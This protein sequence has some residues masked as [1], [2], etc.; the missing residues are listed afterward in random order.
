MTTIAFIGA[1][2]IAKALMGGY[3]AGGPA[4]EVWA[5]DPIEAQLTTLPDGIRTTTNNLEA[6]TSAEI[7]VLCVKPNMLGEICQSLQPVA[8]GKLFISVAAGITCNNLSQWLG[9]NAAIIRC[10][11]NT[12]ALVGAGMT[13]LFATAS[14]SDR[15]KSQGAAI[16]A[17]V[18]KILWFDV[19]TELDAVTAVSGSGPAYFFF[20]LESMQ[21]AA[22]RLG[23][24]PDVAKT[25]VEQTA[26]GAIKMAMQTEA[27]I[28]ELRHNVTSP[29]GTTA[30][31]IGVLEANGFEET[32]FE[33]LKAAADR[34]KALSDG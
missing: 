5:A 13:G 19:E 31:A 14:V 20:M 8:A 15:Q 1:G 11:P 16:L 29:G 2:N 7:V 12:P 33:A 18:G 30:A 9:P 28:A 25:L 24:A 21:V 32:I 10:M 17:T 23:L 6:V 26:F 27:P 3:L 22:T 4:G 34:S